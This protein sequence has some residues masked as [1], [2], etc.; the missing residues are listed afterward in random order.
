MDNNININDSLEALVNNERRRSSSFNQ[1]DKMNPNTEPVEFEK[2]FYTPIHTLS[3]K[4]A[5]SLRESAQIKLTGKDI[6]LPIVDFFN[7]N[8]PEKILRHFE[9]K[10]YTKP[11]AFQ[12]QVWPIVFSGR[13]MV[14]IAS[15]GSG[16]TISYV[17]PALTHAKAQQPLRK[18]DGPIV[19]II[20]PSRELVSQ[21]DQ[22]VQ[23]YCS[24]Y[25]LRSCAVYGGASIVTQMKA[26]KRGVEILVATPG[27]LT[28][29]HEEGFCLLKRVTFLVIDEA[30]RL[31]DMGFEPQLKMII[32]KTHSER[33]SLIL[34]SNC[35]REIK[36][37]ANNYM[38]EYIQVAIG[39]EYSICNIKISQKVEVMDCQDKKN[40]LLFLL[41]DKK[42][43]RVI[44]FC[45]M[46]RTCD[47]IENFL[48]ENG[49]HAASI[50]GDKTQAARDA[51][52]HNFKTCTKF[53][54]IATDVASRGLDVENVKLVI[55]YDFP[56]AI[57]DY[58]YR[59]GRT[60][61]GK[62]D[63]R[64]TFTMFTKDDIRNGRDLIQ[65]LK[66][67]NQDVPQALEN[68][69]KSSCGSFSEN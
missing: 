4:E 54:L 2:N 61:R 15:T 46:K 18:D 16:K 21:I 24:I 32:Q 5:D 47:T 62:V 69:V 59:I 25:D 57:E 7:I 34:S 52:I 30:D 65:L 51:A 26:L 49:F 64:H 9:R 63:E 19:L 8:F 23:E 56:K 68:L 37:L 35:P 29:L 48:G 11:T 22:V 28:D 38:K 53:I 12:A 10:G 31:L 13:D 55:N 67:S 14:G 58:V 60:T 44:I 17:L 27:R 1:E 43:D 36:T 50:H 6:P 66:E 40:R 3:A 39:N 45:N 20:A 41:Q 42:S 33:Q